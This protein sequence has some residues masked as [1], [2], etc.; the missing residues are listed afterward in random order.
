MFIVAISNKHHSCRQKIAKAIETIGYF[1]QIA[2]SF[3]RQNNDES[4]ISIIQIYEY[5]QTTIKHDFYLEKRPLWSSVDI[6]H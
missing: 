4:A 6:R 2:K 3:K 1:S 5:A